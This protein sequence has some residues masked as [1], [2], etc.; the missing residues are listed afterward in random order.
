M[1]VTW[2]CGTG[3]SISAGRRSSHSLVCAVWRAGQLRLAQECQENI[4]VSHCS[5]RRPGR[6]VAAVR[7]LR[8]SS[9]AR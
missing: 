2:K 9:M 8:M 1:K 4:S 5:Q 7:Q 3:G 6:Q